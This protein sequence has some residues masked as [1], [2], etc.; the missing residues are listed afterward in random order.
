MVQGWEVF[1]SFLVGDQEVIVGFDASA[2]KNKYLVSYVR[3]DNDFGMEEYFESIGT[4]EYL[5][6]MSLYSR[7]TADQVKKTQDERDKIGITEVIGLDACM[8]IADLNLENMVVVIRPE[9]L[10]PEY[11]TADRQIMIATG[12]AGC[13]ADSL[14]TSVFVTYLYSGEQGRFNRAHILGVI[15]PERIPDWA[16]SKLGEL[17]NEKQVPI[18][19]V[20]R[21]RDSD[22]R[23]R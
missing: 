2:I 17:R 16:K 4:D 9:L 6:A 7:R 20:A 19:P 22:D 3:K 1:D 15:K 14:G 21:K 18:R 23:E 5:E 12:G 11:Q 8:S 13:R 10:R